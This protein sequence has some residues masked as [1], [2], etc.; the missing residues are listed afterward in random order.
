MDP[1]D[2]GNVGNKPENGHELDGIR[3]AV[4]SDMITLDIKYATITKPAELLATPLVLEPTSPIVAATG[5]RKEK[6]I[7]RKTD[8]L[9]GI[10][11]LGIFL[12]IAA[13]SG[14]N[15]MW[16]VCGGTA[17][18]IFLTLSGFLMVLSFYPA[19]EKSNLSLWG[20]LVMTFQFWTKKFFRIYGPL[21][22]WILFHYTLISK[23]TGPFKLC[24]WTST[25]DMA[26]AIF[27][28]RP[29][30]CPLWYIPIQFGHYLMMPFYALLVF[31]SEKYWKFTVAA[32]LGCSIFHDLVYA[33]GFQ[34]QIDHISTLLTS[35]S[36]GIIYLKC[37]DQL[38]KLAKLKGYKRLLLEYFEGFVVL[39]LISTASRLILFRYFYKFHEPNQR[40]Y[41]SIYLGFIYVKEAYAPSLIAKYFGNP[42][43][44]WI[45]TISYTLYLMHFWVIY[46]R[47]EWPGYTYDKVTS[48]IACWF[49]SLVVG[50]FCY[51]ATERPYNVVMNHFSNWSGLNGPKKKA[52]SQKLIAEMK[53]KLA[54]RFKSI[55]KRANG[56]STEVKPESFA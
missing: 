15:D 34:V 49:Y 46:N 5:N 37:K 44:K 47:P 31:I 42:N 14:L 43:Y 32:A 52:E 45:A 23:E 12:V 19:L 2:K 17:V 30:N 27:G 16:E 10:R 55:F 36:F 22:I 53:E 41:I 13:H 54:P 38:S 6:G 28:G 48:V 9:D 20:F 39:M 35:V 51:H 40:G 33:R 1:T 4:S 18:D 11:A 21:F 25:Q 29:M 24:N 7:R 26:F 50:W 56:A 3:N 8:F